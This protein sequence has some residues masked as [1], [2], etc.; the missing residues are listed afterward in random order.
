M[1]TARIM[2]WTLLA[3]IPGAIVL[4]VQ[5]GWG[6]AANVAAA[7][8]F[9]L[10]CEAGALRL[11]QQPLSQLKDGSAALT[12]AL[13]GL[14]LPPLLPLWMVFVG[15]FM[16]LVFG[17]HVYGGL[18]RNIFNPAMVGYATLL[19]AFPLAM[20]QWPVPGEQPQA[21]TLAGKLTLS[22]QAEVDGMSGATLLDAFKFRQGESSED[23]FAGAAASHAAAWLKVNAAF[24]VGGLL[25]LYLRIL[26]WQLPVGYLATLAVLAL[27]FHDGGSSASL[28]SPVFH[29]FSGGTMLAAFFIITDP[30]T[31]PSLR[32]GLLVFAAGAA[33]LTFLIRTSGAYPDG[34]AF[35]VLLMN[36]AAPL[37][38]HLLLP[39]HKEAA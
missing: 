34:I 11:R 20:S 35:A 12:G 33:A 23:L 19:I 4:T 39:R 15:V 25:L 8:A 21:H 9:A 24:L 26:P 10:V 36:G 1:N 18:G 16:A 29:L 37:L 30:V 6:V 17:K 14:A 5:F 27:I 7:V 28:G 2:Q 38:D 13:L 3:L 22:S 32:R 31:S